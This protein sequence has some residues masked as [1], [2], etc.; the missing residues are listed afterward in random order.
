MSI[1]WREKL[2]AAAIHFL[3]TLTVAGLAAAIVFFVWF[4]SGLAEMIGGRKLFFMV[5]GVDVSLGPLISLI[6]YS[7]KKSRRELVI[8][9]FVVGVVQLAAL[10]YG[11]FAVAVS[12]PVFVVF[13]GGRLEIVTAIELDDKDLT[14]GTAPEFRSLSW[15]GPRLVAVQ[16]PTDPQERN[17]LIFSAVQGKDAQ[18]MPRYYRAYDFARDEIK[19]K[20]K[21]LQTVQ[22]EDSLQQHQF[23]LAIDNAGVPENDLRWLRVHHRF[24]FGMAL[25]DARIEI[26]VRYLPID[27]K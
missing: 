19:Q 23:K 3:I 6:I 16:M 26:P 12:R 7:S 21:S 5:I 11:L 9:Y 18:L 1:N 8:D 4:P 13:H 22:I 17:N 27:P 24:G 20:L 14:Q 2:F 10:L 25:I 15:T